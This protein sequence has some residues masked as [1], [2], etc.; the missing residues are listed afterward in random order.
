MKTKINRGIYI[1]LISL[2]MWSC[3]NENDPSPSSTELILGSWKFST[4]DVTL[5]VG[6]KSFVDYLIE[7]GATAEEA[8]LFSSEFASAF[9]DPDVEIDFKKEGTYSS[10]TDGSTESGTW[11]LSSDGKTLT[12]DK[13]TT[14]ESVFKV[15]KIT[16]KILNLSAE[17]I[18]DSLEDTLTIY[19]DLGLIR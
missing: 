6:N 1:L 15:T 3:G 19:L 7:Q 2:I 16:D 18:D 12:L 8:E 13:G 4:I 5:K 17:L 9:E 14:D 10:T 11:E